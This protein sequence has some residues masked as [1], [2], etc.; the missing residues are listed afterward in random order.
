[1]LRDDEV[2]QQTF[3]L[4]KEI[5]QINS[6]LDNT[7]SLVREAS[8]DD[9][10]GYTCTMQNIEITDIVTHEQIMCYNTT[11]KTC[12]MVSLFLKTFNP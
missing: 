2:E 8:S 10:P 4:R 5:D 3:E 6:Q 1:M 7:N 11:E 12:S 9:P